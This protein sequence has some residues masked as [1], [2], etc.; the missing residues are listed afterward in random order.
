MQEERPVVRQEQRT[1]GWVPFEL[2]RDRWIFMR[3]LVNGVETE[4]M[5][6]SGASITVIDS[7]EAR[8]RGFRG[9]RRI[10]ALGVGGLQEGRLHGGVFVELDGLSLRNLRVAAVDLS[11]VGKHIGRPLPFVL[12]RDVFDKVVVDIDYPNRRVAFHEFAGYEYTGPGATVPLTQFESGKWA[13]ELEIAGV[14]T[15]LFQLDTGGGETVTLFEEFIEAHELLI[16]LP[17]SVHLTGGVGG[18]LEVRTGTLPTL[19]F[20]GVTLTD[21]PASFHA[22]DQGAFAAMDLAGN[23]GGG[24]LERFRLVFHTQRKELYV[25]PGEDATTR[26][27]MRDRTGL[28]TMLT[29]QGL[30]VIHV[31]PGSPAAAAGWQAGT[32][33]QAVDGVAVGPD[34]W[35]TLRGWNWAEPGTLV[36]LRDARGVERELLLEDY[37]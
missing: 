37:F 29:E 35:T 11:D 33:I 30:E 36:R 31:A 10:S 3:A 6:D 5:L 15:G 23:L 19:T 17:T 14:G 21:V 32:L 9:G 34:Y 8:R 22:G 25:Q 18:T 27:F 20:A 4:I 7:A 1:T 24:I 2:F 28:Q 26:R 12:G 16:D 13:A